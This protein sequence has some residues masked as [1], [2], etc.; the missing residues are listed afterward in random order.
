MA[1][2]GNFPAPLPED[3]ES[4]VISAP[5]RGHSVKPDEAYEM[6]ERTYRDLPKIELFA[7]S[8]REGWRSW[9]DQADMAGG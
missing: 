3:R 2:G 8:R 9:G 6:I 7:R 4:S 5:T 1:A